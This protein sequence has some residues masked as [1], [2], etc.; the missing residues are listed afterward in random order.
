M[1]FETACERDGQA[2]IAGLK[3]NQVKDFLLK[4]NTLYK[5]ISDLGTLPG[6]HERHVFLC[7]N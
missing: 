7:R 6:W 2:P 5:H 3:Q 4:P 1:I